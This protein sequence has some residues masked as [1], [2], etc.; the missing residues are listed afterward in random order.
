[1]PSPSPRLSDHLSESLRQGESTPCLRFRQF[2]K[3]SARD[4]LDSGS[5][6]AATSPCH[7]SDEAHRNQNARRLRNDHLRACRVRRSRRPHRRVENRRTAVVANGLLPIQILCDHRVI[8]VESRLID[9][10]TLQQIRHEWRVRKQSRV[11][12]GTQPIRIPHLSAQRIP[13]VLKRHCRSRIESPVIDRLSCE[14][15]EGGAAQPSQT[16]RRTEALLHQ[17]TIRLGTN[18]GPGLLLLISHTLVRRGTDGRRF[19][20][21]RERADYAK[22]QGEIRTRQEPFRHG[23]CLWMSSPIMGFGQEV[24]PCLGPE[25]NPFEGTLLEDIVFIGRPVCES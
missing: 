25:S 15:P 7:E 18:S 21:A 3:L 24:R 16:G 14:I 2:R 20:I 10:S 4:D 17:T 13:N 11:R 8:G 9:Q 1:M 5:R 6:F 19:E 23:E 12:V 22:D